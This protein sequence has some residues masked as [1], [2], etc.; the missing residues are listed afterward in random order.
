MFYKWEGG[1]LSHQ[2]Y[3]LS[4]KPGCR[5]NDEVRKRK[6]IGPDQADGVGRIFAIMAGGAD[7]VGN[8]ASAAICLRFQ[9]MPSE[10]STIRE[11][12]KMGI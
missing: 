10:F 11:C 2:L 7:V 12:V 9:Q 6:P 8:A 5:L 3:R 1:S 4:R